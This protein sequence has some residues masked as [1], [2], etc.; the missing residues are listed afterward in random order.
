[1]S[2]AELTQ[3]RE[4]YSKDRED[5]PLIVELIDEI[6]RLRAE[7]ERLKQDDTRG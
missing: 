5:E 4:W 2:D 3:C 1:M 6:F 7:L